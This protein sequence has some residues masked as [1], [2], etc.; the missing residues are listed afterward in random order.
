MKYKVTYIDIDGDY[1]KCWIEATSVEDARLQASQEY[2][3]I[4]EIV[5]INRLN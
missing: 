1:Q 5:S 4:K 2:W 3:N